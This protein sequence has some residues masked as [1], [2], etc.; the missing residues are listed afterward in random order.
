M[1]TIKT[2]KQLLWASLPALLL[3][4]VPACQTDGELVSVFQDTPHKAIQFAFPK[5]A[6]YTFSINGIMQDSLD[7]RGYSTYIYVPTTVPF[8][9]EV[10]S[11]TD[12]VVFADSLT[13]N[14]SGIIAFYNVLGHGLMANL[15]ATEMHPFAISVAEPAEGVKIVLKGIEGNPQGVEL[16]NGQS[17]ILSQTDVTKGGLSVEVS[18]G[19]EVLY[20]KPVD[21]AA[22]A[23]KLGLL[24]ASEQSL[25]AWEEPTQEMRDQ[26]VEPFDTWVSFLFSAADFPHHKKLMLELAPDAFLVMDDASGFPMNPTTYKEGYA[27]I[28]YELLPDVPA[29][30]QLVNGY[31]E[32]DYMN[33]IK[34]YDP[35]DPDNPIISMDNF[36]FVYP[37]LYNSDDYEQGMPTDPATGKP[38]IYRFRC[39]SITSDKQL[40]F[41]QSYSFK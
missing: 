8:E 32:M 5:G 28:V 37:F 3:L 15:T 20:T 14:E 36:D 24:W 21:K 4:L 2:I 31:N 7:S 41:E 10:S 38:I 13:Y 18:K 27:P 34:L 22:N 19:G 35:E 16:K 11:F 30:F 17:Y 9:V 26:L 29:E 6:E 25:F 1:K 33:V 39:Y 12:E 23:T 40:K